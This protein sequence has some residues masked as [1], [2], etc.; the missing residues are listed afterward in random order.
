MDTSNL[1]SDD[2]KAEFSKRFNNEIPDGFAVAP[3][4]VNLIGE[5]IDYEGYSVLPMAIERNIKIVFQI[6]HNKTTISMKNNNDQEFK[7]FEIENDPSV[8]IDLSNINWAS[9]F[10]C[11][12]IGAWRDEHQTLKGKL[13][14]GLNILVF[15][16]IPL[17]SG[18][19]SSSAM[20]V[21]ST[22]VCKHAAVWYMERYPQ[23]CGDQFKYA[24]KDVDNMNAIADLCRKA[25]KHIGT[26]SGG[27]DQAASCLSQQGC[28]QVIHFDPLHTELV[29]LP[30]KAVFVIADSLTKS[31][32]AHTAHIHYNFRVVECMLATKVLGSILQ[33]ENAIKV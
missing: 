12:F 6:V 33:V 2:L 1:S 15:G 4:R 14:F 24:I 8:N 10:Q 3:G 32:K 21:A 18:L 7:D 25:E 11:G 20:V 26:M 27:M 28:A 19:S 30:E 29:S 9:Y 17:A 5:H 13:P 22:M 16:D 31:E 23:N